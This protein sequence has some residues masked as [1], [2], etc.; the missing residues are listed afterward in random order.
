MKIAFMAI[1]VSECKFFVNVRPP[2]TQPPTE[3]RG[4]ADRGRLV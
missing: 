1:L 4:Q 3:G 2:V